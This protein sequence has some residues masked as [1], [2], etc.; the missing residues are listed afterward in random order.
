MAVK[1]SFDQVSDLGQSARGELFTLLERHFAGVEGDTFATDLLAKT[2]VLRLFGQ[3]GNLAGFS[4]IDYRRRMIDG[5][6]AAVLYSGDT[7]VDPAAWVDASLGPAWV[8]AVLDLHAEQ[9]PL[10]WLVLTSGMRTYR[11]LTVCLCRYA[12]APPDRYDVTA[13]ALLSVLASER[14]GE[15]FNAH[16]G[17]VRF[18][19]PQCL[20][21]HLADVPEHIRDDPAVQV[22]LQRN[23]GHAAG[24]ELVSV[25]RLDVANLTP[26]GLLALRRGRRAAVGAS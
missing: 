14:F 16:T 6:R 26:A 19:N 8:A 11:Y 4:T 10:W 22:F 24:D 7:I 15:S 3:D 18:V 21:H 13:A 25:C 17:V 5:V 20:R 2:H 1:I 23:P 9:G 12:P